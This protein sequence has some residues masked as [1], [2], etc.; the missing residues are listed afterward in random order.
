MKGFGRNKSGRRTPGQT[1]RKDYGGT[2]RRDFSRPC[3]GDYG[4]PRRTFGRPAMHEATCA[5]CGQKCEVPFKPTGDKPVYCR[6]C[7]RK[8]GNTSPKDGA[9]Q[10]ARELDQ[11]NKKLD[12]ILTELDIE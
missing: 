9:G 10:I 1:G 11:I 7:Y 5:K 12:K 4:R 6:N 3:G 2:G 8:D